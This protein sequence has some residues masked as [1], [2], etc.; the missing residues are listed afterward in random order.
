MPMIGPYEVFYWANK[1]DEP[2]DTKIRLLQEHESSICKPC[3]IRQ[4]RAKRSCFLL[5]DAKLN[6]IICSRQK[7]GKKGKGDKFT[8]SSPRLL[9]YPDKL[10]GS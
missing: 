9:S 8:S 7:K 4:L 6:Q 10:L 1:A 3:T 5:W 2:N